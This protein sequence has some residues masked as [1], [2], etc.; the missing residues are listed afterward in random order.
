MKKIA[1]AATILA[2]L[3][4][5]GC[6]TTEKVSLVQTAD[7]DMTC[8]QMK[9]EIARLTIVK[10]QAADNSMNGTNMAAKLDSSNTE[11]LATERRT[12]LKT[13][14]SD[15]QCDGSANV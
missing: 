15:K 4:L 6:T 8:A 2:G 10:A 11:R 12:H 13:Y 7:I 9:G 14:Y 5:T 3:A 1:I